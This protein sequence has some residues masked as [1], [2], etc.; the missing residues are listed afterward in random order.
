[1]AKI[2]FLY[3]KAQDTLVLFQEDK[4]H[5]TIEFGE[6]ILIDLDSKMNIVGIE[7][8]NAS[9]TLTHLMQRRIAKTDLANIKN[10]KLFSEKRA[11]LITAFFTIQFAHESIRDKIILAD[12]KY[13]S[14]ILARAR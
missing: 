1:M 12:T 8:F 2:K 11:G 9:K 7:F 14:P 3:D 4:S 5:G 6:S 13:A 10:A